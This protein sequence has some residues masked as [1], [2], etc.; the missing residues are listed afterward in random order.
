MTTENK[1]T[2]KL[3]FEVK[4]F[5]MTM[6]MNMTN[7]GIL[8]HS[9]II[10]APGHKHDGKRIFRVIKTPKKHNQWG[11]GVAYFHLEGEPEKGVPNM[12]TPKAFARYYFPEF[13][14][15]KT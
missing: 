12:H 14:Q 10:V 13:Y 5:Q 8:Q 3:P 11:E 15:S 7:E 4:D 6:H 2:E 1:N 9:G